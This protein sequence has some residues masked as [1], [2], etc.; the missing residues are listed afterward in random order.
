MILQNGNTCE[1]LRICTQMC[2]NKHSLV[3]SREAGGAGGALR[4][5]GCAAESAG[6]LGGVVWA[7]LHN[8]CGDAGDGH[9]SDLDG[10]SVEAG[11]VGFFARD[12]FS[13]VPFHLFLRVPDFFFQV[14]DQGFERLDLFQVFWARLAV[15]DLLFQLGDLACKRRDLFVFFFEFCRVQGVLLSLAFC[16]FVFQPLHVFPV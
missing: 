12:E 5:A 9:V 7:F 8:V 15:C 16:E 3:D 2:A 11:V 13:L 6:G 14:F 1:F 10:V 4:L